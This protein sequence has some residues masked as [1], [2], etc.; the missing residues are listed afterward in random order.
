MMFK[1]LKTILLAVFTVQ[2][3]FS[4]A[5]DEVLLTIDDEPVMA[6]EFIRVYNKNL[7]L[8]TDE[9]Q[10]NV[11]GYLKLF[12][13][14]KLKLKEAKRL[15]LDENPKYKREFGNY[16][17]QLTQKYLAENEVTNALMQEAYSRLQQD[18]KASH[19]LVRIDAKNDTL[20]AYNKLMKLRGEA[21]DNG[22]ESV[23]Q[24]AHNGKDVIIEDL[25]YFSAFKMVYDFEN[26][27]F[28]TKVGDISMPFKTR[29]GYH[30]VYVQKKQPTQGYLTIA[31]IM[32]ANSQNPDA[33]DTEKRINEIYNMLQQGKDFEALAKQF[34]EDKS[35]ASNGGKIAP[36]RRGRLGSEA[37]E[38]AAFGLQ[39]DGDFSKPVK[40]KYGWH[41]I[42]RIGLEPIK[43]M[44]D[45]EAD[46]QRMIKRDTRSQLIE[47]AKVD[48]LKKQYQV[49][50]N[51]KSKLY[52]A[53]IL[54]KDFYNNK[55]KTPE[56]FP[57]N[58]KV[59]TINGK[60]YTYQ[61]FES[62]LRLAQRIYT[63]SNVPFSTIVNTEFDKFFNASILK[64]RS[65]NL[66]TENQEYAN[67]LT[68]YR[69]GLLLFDLM[70]QEIWQKATNDSIGLTNYYNTNKAKYQWPNRVDA[71]LA[72]ATN[73]KVAKQV[74]K[75]L[76]NGKN[77]EQISQVL[78]SADTQKVIF[79]KGKMPLN[80][81]KL[82]SNFKAKKG[83][84]KV[85]NNNNT[86]VVAL[87]KEVLQPTQKPFN[88]ARGNV[89]ADYQNTIEQ[90][91]LNQLKQR[92]KVVVNQ[93]VLKNVKA[94]LK[95]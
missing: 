56:N 68:E 12:T 76:K 48:K 79:T 61:N 64:Y 40:T 94:Q 58:N 49:T 88:E 5:K 6:S 55:W 16:K 74:R 34:S 32:I 41:I 22:F 45:M 78:N 44:A 30:V 73:K 53:S 37:F 46:L 47:Q 9:S 92:Y 75:M 85:Y 39:N 84:S 66:A 17:N 13:D 20:A 69:D 14:Y 35:T 95:Q 63:N 2:L 38:D 23:K 57:K 90:D 1:N 43:S 10:K 52:F 82:P 93:D 62:R 72:T 18:V 54:N 7:D 29:F 15:K 8:V 50:V 31:H 71:I 51:E 36:F 81:P 28:N 60:A 3:A 19:I 27:A 42:K 26:A 59:F 21:I 25:G 87:V 86:Y 11:D 33:V 77:Q 83:V 24:T 65:D 89:V 67:I 91:W 4:Q 80:S 70:E